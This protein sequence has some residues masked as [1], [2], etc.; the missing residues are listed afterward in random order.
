VK[1]T[2]THIHSAKKF[3]DSFS[4]KLCG[5]RKNTSALYVQ[6]FTFWVVFCY[7]I[8]HFTMLET[9]VFLLTCFPYIVVFYAVKNGE[10][11]AENFVYTAV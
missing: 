5:T 4:V 6:V 8:V 2:H 1:G 10:V 3:F 9:F 7:Y 11:I